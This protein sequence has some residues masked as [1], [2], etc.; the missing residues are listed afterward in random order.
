MSAGL[1][2]LGCRA[3]GFFSEFG[4]FKDRVPEKLV[5]GMLSVVSGVASCWKRGLE[6]VV[7]SLDPG[8]G[9]RAH[10]AANDDL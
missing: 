1:A 9:I 2:A 7:F 4:G 3:L 5:C 10:R 6:P 8:P